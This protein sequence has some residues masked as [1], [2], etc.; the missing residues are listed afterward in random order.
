MQVIQFILEM[1]EYQNDINDKEFERY[2]TPEIEPKGG[3][4]IVKK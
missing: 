1:S 4:I 2:F 3:K